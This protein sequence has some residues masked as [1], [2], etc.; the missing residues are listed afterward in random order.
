MQS[1]FSTNFDVSSIAP[2]KFIYD[3]ILHGWR[4]VKK[5]SYF[6]KI[7]IRR[8]IIKGNKYY[9]IISLVEGEDEEVGGGGRG[10]RDVS[11]VEAELDKYKRKYEN[12]VRKLRD[13]VTF[14]IQFASNERSWK[15]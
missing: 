13:K 9:Y 1:I 7:I 11:E 2:L 3:F 15:V 10:W 6:E 14:F 5:S 12:L 8:C 4:C